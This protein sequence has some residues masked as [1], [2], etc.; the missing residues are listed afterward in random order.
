MHLSGKT[1]WN[2][3]HAVRKAARD[4]PPQAAGVPALSFWKGRAWREQGNGNTS[5]TSPWVHA[6]GLQGAPAH[7]QEPR[8]RSAHGCQ[9]LAKCRGL[10]FP[11]QPGGDQQ[12]DSLLLSLQALGHW[13]C[14]ASLVKCSS[15]WEQCENVK[16]VGEFSPQKAAS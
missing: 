5:C 8:P 16:S 13:S 3:A 4:S 15:Y 10:R 14:F 2:Q 9:L 11:L 7:S 1:P 12:K 6:T